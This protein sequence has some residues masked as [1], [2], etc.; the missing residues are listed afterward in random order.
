MALEDLVPPVEL[1]ELIPDDSFSDS[2]FVWYYPYNEGS[3]W[4]LIMRSDAGNEPMYPAP[5]LLEL[6]EAL[7]VMGRGKGWGDYLY[8]WLCCTPKAGESAD[9]NPATEA[10][11]LWLIVTAKRIRIRK[12]RKVRQVRKKLH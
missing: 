10:L 12:V 5:T 3:H 9:T 4:D 11:L 8:K 1:C 6:F 7:F 2:E